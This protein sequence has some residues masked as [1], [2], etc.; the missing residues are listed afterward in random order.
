CIPTFTVATPSRTTRIP[1]PGRTRKTLA[2]RVHRSQELL[3][4][5]GEL[6]LVQQELHS[7]DRVELGQR[8]AEEPDLLELVL[9]EEQLF[10]PGPGLLDVDRGEDPLVHQPAVQVALH[11]AGALELF[12]DY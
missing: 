9:L 6:E 10:L 8:L 3:V 1:A 7:L 5:L 12:E 4:G 2:H 11:V